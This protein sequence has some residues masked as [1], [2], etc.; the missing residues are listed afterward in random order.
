M[1]EDTGEFRDN[2]SERWKR[3]DGSERDD[4]MREGGWNGKGTVSLR[5]DGT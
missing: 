1:N 3:N 4:G 2:E 5:E